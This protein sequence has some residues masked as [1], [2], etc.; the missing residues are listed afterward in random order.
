MIRTILRIAVPS[1][2][3]AEFEHRFIQVDVLGAAARAAGLR[4]GELLRPPRGGDYVVTAT[5]DGPEAYQVWR[6]SAAK[7]R[8]G[9]ALDGLAMPSPDPEVYDVLH[10]YP[11][12]R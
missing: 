3:E 11:P 4:T 7:E 5:W 10:V 6:N 2:R 9:A 8:T 12:R 1:G